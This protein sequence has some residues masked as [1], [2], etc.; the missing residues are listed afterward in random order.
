MLLLPLTVA[1]AVGSALAGVVHAPFR[2]WSSAGSSS[3]K[4]GSPAPT[5]RRMSVDAAELHRVRP[6]GGRSSIDGSA[7]PAPARRASIDGNFKPSGGGGRR[8]SIDA[9]RRTPIDKSRRASVD[10][11]RRRPSPPSSTGRTASHAAAPPP[12]AGRPRRGTHEAGARLPPTGVTPPRAPPRPAAPPSE[13]RSNEDE[14]DVFPHRSSFERAPTRTEVRAWAGAPPAGGRTSAAI[15]VGGVAARSDLDRVPTR[16][17]V[18]AYA[19][20]APAA[21]RPAA[22]IHGGVASSSGGGGGHKGKKHRH[23]AK[24]SKGPITK[25]VAA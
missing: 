17:E 24:S 4:K 22:T 8:S 11:G 5:P 1:R 2:H 6:G 12:A 23:V 21:G 19:G 20:A 13:D 9:G 14:D 25:A 15:A 16:T 18:R 10:Q 3:P 7:R